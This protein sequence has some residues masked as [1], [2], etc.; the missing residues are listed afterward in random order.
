VT[1]DAP[2]RVAMVGSGRSTHTLSR[3]AAVA[4][5][6]HSVRLVT[7]G[8][9]LPGASVEV[10][11]RPLPRGPLGAVE[12]ARG[13]WRDLRDFQPELLHVHYA[14][15][16]LGTLATL[17]GPW[18]LAVTV[19]GGDVLPEQHPGG[20][21]PI[22]RRATR[23]ILERADVIL[24]KSDALRPAIA[25]LGGSPEL[26]ET[27]RWGVDPE[28]FRPDPEA[29]DALRERLGLEPGRRVV[30]S[31]RLLRPLYNVHLVLEAMPEV[32]ARAPE[33]LLLVTDYN[34]EPGYRDRLERSVAELGIAHAVRFAGRIDHTDMPALYGLS[35]AVVSV[36]SSDGLPQTLFEAMA[37]AVPVV[38]GKLPAYAEVV[39]HG[40]TALLV[41]LEPR[42][43]AAAILELIRSPE[44]RR[45]LG[46]NARERVKSIASLSRELDRVERCYRKALRRPR[47][48]R[49]ERLASLAD[50][51]SL[52]IR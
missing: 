11:T 49:A 27:V 22:E 52:A 50:L 47:P 34:A 33:A 48:R 29:A 25:A 41:E 45:A 19:M 2:L 35:Q 36:P 31:P 20:H 16:R 4:S 42:A 43:I 21:R 14:G 10:R 3:A 7:L 8:E 51:L 28:L 26:V 30:L 23:R 17:A 39:R 9:V 5:R 37:C 12:A 46:R 24:A 1:G 44:R 18:P 32:L 38:L 15:G 13:F 6:G 40:E